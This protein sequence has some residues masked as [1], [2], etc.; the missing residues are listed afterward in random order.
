MTA[1]AMA[2][3]PLAP[4]AQPEV[5][6]GCSRWD[7][8][9][10]KVRRDLRVLVKHRL[11]SGPVE[12]DDDWA[13]VISDALVFTLRGPTLD[14]MNEMMRRCGLMCDEAIAM[15]AINRTRA[16]I[17]RKG[18]AA[19]RLISNRVRGEM[20]NATL[21]EVIALRL[22]TMTPVDETQ[23]EA[24]Q[25]RRLQRRD[26]NR[27]R[28]RIRRAKAGAVPQAKSA[29][30]HQPWRACN[31]SRA[32]WYR[33]GK[34]TTGTP[35][36][37]SAERAA[38]RKAKDAERKRRIRRARGAQSRAASPSAALRQIRQVA[39]LRGLARERLKVST[40]SLLT[41]N[42]SQTLRDSPSGAEKLQFVR[43]QPKSCMCRSSAAAAIR[44]ERMPSPRSQ[45]APSPSPHE[46]GECA[47]YHGPFVSNARARAP[48]HA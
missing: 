17:K 6:R 32:T 30:R 46:M 2:A 4:Q 41:L 35:H 42:E 22:T 43:R 20:L 44:P 40:S 23:S 11:L 29:M 48:A 16:I 19:Y 25:R 10:A 26:Y 5:S 34:P 14:G 15:D 27:D 31:M 1:I 36:V 37:T 24:L 47:S 33:K 28:G 12:V 3:S 8:M 7:G 9:A 45:A 13:R 39:I 38:I 18:R 21:E